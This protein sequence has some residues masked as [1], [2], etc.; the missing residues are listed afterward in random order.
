MNYK[1]RKKERKLKQNLTNIY[2]I[3][4]IKSFNLDF[5]SK[6]IL[7]WLAI[8]SF[9][10]F[11]PWL[12][13]D[14]HSIS[15]NAFSNIWWNIWYVML[16]FIIIIL[17]I[18]FSNKTWEKLKLASNINFKN[19]III[20]FWSSFIIATSIIFIS[21]IR[22][23]N[24]FS[25]NIEIWK[26]I[27][28]YLLWGIVILIWWIIKRKNYYKNEYETFIC[29]TQNKELIKNDKSNMKLPF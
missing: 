26:W 11:T 16:F 10:L 28:M 5:A 25:V 23:L 17:F 1:E 2:N 18:I 20:I 24:I 27:I 12:Y 21:F 6:I 29:E 9:S 3:F 8:L 7:I 4:K 22:W 13:K 14:E 19:Y 15:W